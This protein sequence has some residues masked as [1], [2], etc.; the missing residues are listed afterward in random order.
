MQPTLQEFILLSEVS[1]QHSLFHHYHLP[2]S[3]IFFWT[4][5]LSNRHWDTCVVLLQPVFPVTMAMMLFHTAF[6]DFLFGH[7]SQ[8]LLLLLK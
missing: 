5:G 2:L 3:S 6:G 8:E 4:E 1:G 7:I